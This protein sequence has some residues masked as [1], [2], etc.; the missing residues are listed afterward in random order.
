MTWTVLRM[1]WTAL[2][3]TRDATQSPRFATAQPSVLSQGAGPV[4]AGQSQRRAADGG[5]PRVHLGPLQPL[6]LFAA[7]S[8][9]V[10]GYLTEPG[11]PP[12][13]DYRMIEALGF[14]LG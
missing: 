13:D 1:T 12:A 9:F 6:G 14:T 7:N 3:M 8:M 10:G 11:Q 4:S 5:G 2:R